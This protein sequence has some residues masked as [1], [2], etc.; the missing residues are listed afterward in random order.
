MRVAFVV[1]SIMAFECTPPAPPPAFR[2]ESLVVVSQDE[3]LEFAPDGLLLQRIQ[4]PYPPGGIR[5]ASEAPRDLVFDRNRQLHVF[6][7]I[8][9]PHLSTYDP[10]T[11][12]WEHR[13]HPGWQGTSNVAHGGIVAQ[14][15]RVFVSN[16]ARPGIGGIIL[17]DLT[18]G[19]S[20]GFGEIVDGRL[21]ENI[22][23]ALGPDGLLYALNIQ[24]FHSVDVYDPETLSL[25]R[26]QPLGIPSGLRSIAVGS[27][28]TVYLL[29]NNRNMYQLR[30]GGALQSLPTPFLSQMDLQFDRDGRFRWIDQGEG[31]VA[32]ADQT[33]TEFESFPTHRP[34]TF[35]TLAPGHLVGAE[36][37][38]Q[39]Q[40]D[41]R[42]QGL[43]SVAVLGGPSFP[44]GEII[45]GTLRLGA[46]RAPSVGFSRVRDS[47]GDGLDDLVA[48]F[49]IPS[50]GLERGDS[51]VCVSGRIRSGDPFEGCSSIRTLDPEP[52]AMRTLGMVADA[53]TQTAVIFD[54]DR[55]EVLDRVTL[56]T[57]RGAGADCSIAFDQ[58]G[59]YFQF[60]EDAWVIDLDEAAP[61]TGG[62]RFPQS[63]SSHATLSPDQRSIVACEQSL[64]T[65]YDVRS[66]R[67]TSLSVG[68]GG[69]D[70]IEMCPDKSILV[71]MGNSVVRLILDATGNLIDS[72]A[73][74]RFFRGPDNLSCAPDGA[75]A[76]G[77]VR[78][79]GEIQSFSLPDLTPLSSA[80]IGMGVSSA[81]SENG[82]IV[83]TRVNLGSFPYR[84][85]AIDV[86]GYDPLAG[87]FGNVPL[88]RIPI[89]GI[90]TLGVRDQLAVHPDG[91]RLYVSQRESTEN[92]LPEVAVLDAETG[93][94]LASLRDRDIVFP[95]GVCLTAVPVGVG[96]NAP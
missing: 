52:L 56:P 49:Q 46:G 17:F 81:F 84:D 32:L 75:T 44:A 12:E 83:Y 15:S 23:L 9:P 54:A 68:A 35:M 79:F 62:I 55:D 73:R 93:E 50:V 36:I 7:G 61:V 71:A 51:E 34:V 13:T 76:S 38:T 87:D 43:L 95:T 57:G 65:V 47:D 63:V 18:A 80:A 21:A 72:G 48:K 3:I 41:P 74:L 8:G 40:V 19:T 20:Q 78:S 25:V 2:P 45:R 33:L 42:S 24:F 58:R 22:D 60:R 11:K 67:R 30:P 14:G 92:G 26:T 88:L 91:T 96:G 82:E 90:N 5:P 59:Y 4:V 66:P 77:L 69:C 16:F 10:E 94:R 89:D 85:S 29:G 70:A 39:E 37:L 31:L 27:D 86:R 64:V 28:G 6:N 53:V 1:L